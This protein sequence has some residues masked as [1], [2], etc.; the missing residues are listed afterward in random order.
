MNNN[1]TKLSIRSRILK[2]L[3]RES[4][5][6]AA[7]DDFSE[8]FL[9]I[10]SKRGRFIAHIWVWLQILGLVPTALKESIHLA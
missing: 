3:L 1:Q 8:Q 4:I 5:S 6:D 7:L 2:H 9:Y 10:A